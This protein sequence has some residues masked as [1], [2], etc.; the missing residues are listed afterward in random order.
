M[1]VGICGIDKVFYVG[2]LG[3]VFVVLFIV[4]GYENFGVVVKV[5]VNVINVKVGDWVMVDLNIYCG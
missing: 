3:F 4:L 2:L 5:G 1:F